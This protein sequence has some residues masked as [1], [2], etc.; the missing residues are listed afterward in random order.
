[1]EQNTQTQAQFPQT[2]KYTN[3][4]NYDNTNQIK[5]IIPHLSTPLW[6]GE[7]LGGKYISTTDQAKIIPITK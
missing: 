5:K 2:S 4:N 7:Q 1:M 3:K 6:N